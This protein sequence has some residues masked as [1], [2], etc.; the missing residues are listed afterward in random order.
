MQ[1][2]RNEEGPS[3]ATIF[4]D[5]LPGVAFASQGTSGELTVWAKG[6]R[7]AARLRERLGAG[8]TVIQADRDRLEASISV[9]QISAR[10]GTGEILHDPSGVATRSRAVV[11]LA[12]TMRAHLGRLLRLALFD[13]ERRRVTLVL[14]KPK[15]AEA[16][17]VNEALLKAQTALALASHTVVSNGAA[18][19]DVLYAFDAPRGRFAPIDALTVRRLRTTALVERARRLI[20]AGAG[21]ASVISHT[22]HAAQQDL[23]RM[24]AQTPGQATGQTTAQTGGGAVGQVGAQGGTA[25]GEGSYAVDALITFGDPAFR[26][27]LDG[28]ALRRDGET[29]GEIGS[30]LYRRD[31][32]TGLV[33]LT[34]RWNDLGPDE[35]WQVGVEAERYMGRTTLV[36]E[37]G[38]ED[39]LAGRD[40]VYG[41]VG[42]GYYPNDRT[43]L[44]LVAGY[45]LGEPVVQASVEFQPAGEA[46]PGLSLFADGGM[47]V[48]GDGFVTA[49]LRYAFGS[50]RTLIERDRREIVRRRINPLALALDS[51]S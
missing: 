14:A 45:T 12:Q 28:M 17:R 13:A 18:T 20:L 15:K 36:G 22:A 48:N 41:N 31:P 6:P 2:R 46:L 38:Y 16:G 9:A 24:G 30:H 32:E 19:F 39:G 51:Q 42:V 49:G 25:D 5:L 29:M 26:V 37:I 3:P 50:G 40:D 21:L 27:Q 35:R 47:G 11:A 33:G 7:A 8:A 23:G 1:D 10:F 44:Y 43:S 4:G 34:A